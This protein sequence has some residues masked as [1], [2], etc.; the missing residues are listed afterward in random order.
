ML[1]ICRI[2][3]SFSNKKFGHV[4]DILIS[5]E[6][7]TRVFCCVH[8]GMVLFVHERS[9]GEGEKHYFTCCD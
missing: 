6:K 3:C 9:S 5:I 4:A 1:Y 7:E 8:L 2:Y